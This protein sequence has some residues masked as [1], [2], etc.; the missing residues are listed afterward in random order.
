MKETK[1]VFILLSY[2]CIIF[3]S[4]KF[5]ESHIPKFTSYGNKVSVFILLYLLNDPLIKFLIHSFH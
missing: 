5:I 3:N 4:G 1:C 2:Q